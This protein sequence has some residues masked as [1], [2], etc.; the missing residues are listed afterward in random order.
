MNQISR[1]QV[2]AECSLEVA[3][4]DSRMIRRK[5]WPQG[6]RRIYLERSL[7]DV[8]DEQVWHHLARTV[9]VEVETCPVY[10][11]NPCRHLQRSDESIESH[12]AQLEN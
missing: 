4:E 7:F 2:F 10:P 8:G 6:D 5:V 1:A 3:G 9:L 12:G 11:L